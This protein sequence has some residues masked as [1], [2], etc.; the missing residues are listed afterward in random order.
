MKVCRACGN[1][2]QDSAGWCEVCGTHFSGNEEVVNPDGVGVKEQKK[3]KTKSGRSA[4]IISTVIIV[5]VARLIGG[6]LGEQAAKSQ[7][8]KEDNLVN[9]IE[10]YSLEDS[11]YISGILEDSEYVSEYFGFRFGGD[12]N[13]E[14]Y[15]ES[16]TEL[17]S[18]SFRENF[19]GGASK[20]FESYNLN[21]KIIAGALAQKWKETAYCEIEMMASYYSDDDVV[22]EVMVAVM[23][24]YGFDDISV[25]SLMEKQMIE[26][27]EERGGVSRYLAGKK[28]SGKDIAVSVD[29][30]EIVNRLLVC[31]ENG[32]ICLIIC[33]AVEGYEDEV[34]ESFEKNVMKV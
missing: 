4:G 22:G 24:A 21:D 23:S 2:A 15:N 11:G 6:F 7:L 32:N 17:A 5:I 19:F 34:F 27:G 18:E 31:K 12:E 20:A 13:W 30:I 29:G 16:D 25:D 1:F 8:R 26:G 3:K 10:E 14:I 9:S 28:Y 33:R